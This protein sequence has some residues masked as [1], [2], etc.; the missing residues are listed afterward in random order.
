MPRNSKT[1]SVTLPPGRYFVGDISYALD[2]NNYKLW[3]DD[4]FRD[5]KYFGVSKNDGLKY[6]FVV[7]ETFNGD[8]T[9]IGSDSNMYD[10]DASNI[11]LVPKQ[12]CKSSLKNARNLGMFYDFRG[13]VKFNSRSRGVMNI[14]SGTFKLSIDTRKQE[15]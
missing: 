7:C 5:G 3:L 13:P 2:D 10:S 8:G 9:F 12:L 15:E 6:P 4:G 14:S 11:G 1:V